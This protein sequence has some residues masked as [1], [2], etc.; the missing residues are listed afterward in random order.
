MYNSSR[1][2]TWL[3]TFVEVSCV[4]PL[5]ECVA[6][7]LLYLPSKRVGWCCWKV[8]V[9]DRIQEKAR[10]RDIWGSEWKLYNGNK[11]QFSIPESITT[12]PRLVFT[13]DMELVGGSCFIG[14]TEHQWDLNFSLEIEWSLRYTTLGHTPNSRTDKPL[15]SFKTMK[16]TKANRTWN[17]KHEIAKLNNNDADQDL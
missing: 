10:G 4:V 11:A 7:K 12:N 5:V 15:L 8:I 17:M 13:F 9:V 3:F 16:T 2:P 14:W 1:K 6:W